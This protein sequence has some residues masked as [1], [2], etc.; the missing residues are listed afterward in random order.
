MSIEMVVI[1][2]VGAEKYRYRGAVSVFLFYVRISLNICFVLVTRQI[3]TI[4]TMN[5]VAIFFASPFN[6]I[7][8]KIKSI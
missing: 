1:G 6:F 3:P 5:G 2:G 8:C 7:Y 4:A